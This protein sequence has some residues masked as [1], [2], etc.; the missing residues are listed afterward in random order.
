MKQMTFA[1]MAMSFLSLIVGLMVLYSLV[2]HQLQQRKKDLVLLNI[3]GIKKHRLLS[4]IKKEFLSLVFIAS[5]IGGVLGII[6]SY[7]LSYLFFDANWAG[8]LMVPVYL[9]LCCLTLS[10]LI[11][12]F[13][14][15]DLLTR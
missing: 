3:I 5:V 8:S 15:R 11:V 10:Y 4:M 13:S 9:G 12:R 7:L 6:V 1:L 14:S 2:G